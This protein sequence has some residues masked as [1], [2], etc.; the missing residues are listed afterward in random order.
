MFELRTLRHN[1]V[2]PCVLSD[3]RVLVLK[4]PAYIM[5]PPTRLVSQAFI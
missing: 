2:Y 1:T 3:G 4:A 5:Q